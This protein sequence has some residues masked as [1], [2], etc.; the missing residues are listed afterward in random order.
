MAKHTVMTFKETHYPKFYLHE[1]V[2][3]FVIDSKAAVPELA[4]GEVF[5]QIFEKAKENAKKYNTELGKKISV[6]KMGLILHGFGLGML[7]KYKTI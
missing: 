6:K 7:K 1:C 4:L 3:K 5:K 2:S